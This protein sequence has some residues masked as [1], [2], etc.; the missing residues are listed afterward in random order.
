MPDWGARR[1]DVYNH[2]QNINTCPNHI[3]NINPQN[4]L[5]QF[6]LLMT[7]LNGGGGGGGGLGG[8]LTIEVS[9]NADATHL[10][11]IQNCMETENF[12]RTYGCLFSVLCLNLLQVPLKN[13]QDS[14]RLLR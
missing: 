6:A 10:T 1:S 3:E 11:I 4:G 12:C 9:R 8:V 7:F 2:T 13:T 5:M 14:V